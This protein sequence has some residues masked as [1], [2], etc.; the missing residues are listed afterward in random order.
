MFKSIRG[1]LER[2]QQSIGRQSNAADITQQAVLIFLQQSYSDSSARISV[3]YQESDNTLVIV[4]P[5]K[6]LAGE[7]SLHIPEL[8]EHLTSQGVRVGRIIVR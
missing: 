2:R 7:L 8:K 1:T 5:S 3:R 4:T 6:T